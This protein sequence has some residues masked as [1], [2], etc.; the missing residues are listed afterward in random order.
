MEGMLVNISVLRP[1]LAKKKPSP[2]DFG[3][4][5]HAEV[6][7]IK[8]LSPVYR[9]DVTFDKDRSNNKKG[10]ALSGSATLRLCVAATCRSPSTADRI[11][12]AHHHFIQT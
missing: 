4:H 5:F 3:V 7:V 9:D 1:T 11:N 8:L 12:E 10:E 2:A 6:Y